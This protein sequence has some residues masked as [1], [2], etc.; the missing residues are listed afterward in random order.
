M[1]QLVGGKG[2]YGISMVHHEIHNIYDEEQINELLMHTHTLTNEI[3]NGNWEKKN[4]AP[5]H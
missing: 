3:K 5:I 4:G 2:C 1:L